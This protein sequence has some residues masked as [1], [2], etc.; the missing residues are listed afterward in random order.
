MGGGSGDVVYSP[1]VVTQKSFADR[2]GKDVKLIACGGISSVERANERREIG[3]CNE[4]QIFTPLIFEGTELLRK[5]R[6]G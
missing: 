2:V 4:I 5:L 3:N 1:S 6:T